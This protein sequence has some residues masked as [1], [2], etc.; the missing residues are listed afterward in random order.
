MAARRG[1]GR[2]ADARR[3]GIGRAADPARQHSARPGLARDQP[4]GRAVSFITISRR[5]TF[6]QAVLAQDA[7][8]LA[9][10]EAEIARRVRA[11]LGRLRGQ[12]KAEARAEAQARLEARLQEAR[13]EL[14]QA[15]TATASALA[16]LA[17][18][19]AQVE[20]DL[21]GLVVELAFILARHIAGGPAPPAETLLALVTPLLA[22][23]AAERTPRQR[24]TLR[25]NPADRAL[26]APLLPDP[27]TLLAEDAAIA[28]GGA[29]LELD[30]PD[31]D[32]QARIEWDA[33]LKRRFELAGE[34]L[35]LGG[36]A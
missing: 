26:L 31:G 28:P 5:Q 33:T 19:L 8:Q 30:A 22:E 15:A 18:P 24:L 12:A 2:P 29:R 10:Q 14:A 3:P 13:A 27:A 35:G 4:G 25:L 17:A 36:T 16:Q 1:D 32:P 20:H 11:E 21:A 6:V 34:A 9:A 7:A 23:A